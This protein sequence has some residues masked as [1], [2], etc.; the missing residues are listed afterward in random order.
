MENDDLVEKPKN[1]F[2]H[3]DHVTRVQSS[4]YWETLSEA[5]RKQ[6][7]NYMVLR[8]LSMNYDWLPIIADLQ[9]Y[10]Q[11]LPP[12]TLYKLLINGVIPKKKVFLKYVN[13]INDDKYEPWLVDLFA[14]HYNVSKKEVDIYLKI[15][16]LTPDGKNHIKS[17]AEL[18]GT[19]PKK[20]K[21]L[22]LD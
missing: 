9:P 20:I 14:N 1:L 3:L 8:F 6:W 12:P 10:I 17:V 13:G 16:Y 22:K 15:L 19:D 2:A 4:N 11:E 21:K 18:Y 5:S 7:S